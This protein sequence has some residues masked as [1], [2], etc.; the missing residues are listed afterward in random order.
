M[1]YDQ[2]SVIPKPVKVI[3]REGNFILT[4]QT[5]IESDPKLKDVA[6][7]FNNLISPATGFYLE[8]SDLTIGLTKSNTIYLKLNG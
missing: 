8:I 5:K 7:Y 6:E 1:Q 4:A 3:I 2:I